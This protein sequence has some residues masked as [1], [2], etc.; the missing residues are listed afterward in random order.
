ML[1]D[2]QE[3]CEIITAFQDA[4]SQYCTNKNNP[5]EDRWNVFKAWKYGT[6]ERCSPY[7]KSVNEDYFGY[8]SI[9]HIDRYGTLDIVRAYDLIKEATTQSKDHWKRKYIESNP[10]DLDAFRE[11]I[12]AKGDRFYYWDW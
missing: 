10:V 5:L 3:M 7:F 9:V 1:K 4:I 6:T 8:D 11:E 2:T 12:L